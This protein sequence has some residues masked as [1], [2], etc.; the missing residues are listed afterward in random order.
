M[1]GEVE[2]GMDAVAGDAGDENLLWRGRLGGDADGFAGL[3]V[4]EQRGLAGG[5]EDDEAGGGR[6]AVADHVSGELERVEAAV[7]MERRGERDVEAVE[8]H[9]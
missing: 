7:R 9:S 3:V 8:E 1:A 5:P 2:C 4:G 6:A